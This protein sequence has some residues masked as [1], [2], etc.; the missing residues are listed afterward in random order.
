MIDIRRFAIA[1]GLA[2][3]VLGADHATAQSTYS[4]TGKLINQNNFSLM[5]PIKG[6]LLCPELSWGT[7]RPITS[8]PDPPALPLMNQQMWGGLRAPHN[9]GGCIPGAAVIMTPGMGTAAMVGGMFTLPVM[10]F[11]QVPDGIVAATPLRTLERIVQV[12]SS[13]NFSA[14]PAESTRSEPINATMGMTFAYAPWR[15]FQAGAHVN[16]TGR[17]GPTFTWCPAIVGG[18]GIA[19]CPAPGA[20]GA[21]PLWIKN[22]AGTASPGGFGGTMSLVVR[23][24]GAD[25]GNFAGRVAVGPF[26]MGVLIGPVEPCKGHD[27]RC[28]RTRASIALGRGYAAYGMGGAA[29]IGDVFSMYV[30]TMMFPA[31][32]A[33]IQSVSGN[34]IGTG[35]TAYQTSRNFPWTTGHVIVRQTGMTAGGMNNA[36]TISAKGGDVVTSMGVRNIQL[37]SGKLTTSVIGG[38]PSSTSGTIARMSLP[39]PGGALPLLAGVV[40][41][42]A[43]AARRARKRRS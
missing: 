28:T 16:Q 33:L 15:V 4:M 10:F 7:Q 9:N 43:I 31:E 6:D 1:G 3:L 29:V 34:L 2:A 30:L 42:I 22:L 23:A 27:P 8:Q 36:A 13:G 11:E 21:R 32:S 20:I 17:A 38:V 12:A 24:G 39:E 37:V 25:A 26:T 5:V 18:M 35:P 19:G 14:P 40:G 41:L